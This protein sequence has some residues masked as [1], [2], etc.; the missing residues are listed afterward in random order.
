MMLLW[1][2]AKTFAGTDH[3]EKRRAE[4]KKFFQKTRLAQPTINADSPTWLLSR[5]FL[6]QALTKVNFQKPY[7]KSYGSA[8]SELLCSMN[9]PST[10]GVGKRLTWCSG[11]T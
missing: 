9:I 1:K 8:N 11:K 6:P 2:G 4:R 5:H 7:R 10:W 3:L